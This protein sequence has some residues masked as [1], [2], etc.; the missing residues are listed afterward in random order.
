MTD[1][2]FRA[3]LR[4]FIAANLPPDMAARTLMGYHPHKPDVLYWTDKLNARGWSRGGAGWSRL[5]QKNPSYR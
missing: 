2:E 5:N 3:E 1:T 4:S